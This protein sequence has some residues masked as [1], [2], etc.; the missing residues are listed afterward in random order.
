MYITKLRRNFR[1]H[2][3]ILELPNKMFY[4]GDLLVSILKTSLLCFILQLKCPI[5]FESRTFLFL[6]VI[7]TVCYIHTD[8]LGEL[9]NLPYP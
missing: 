8:V 2:K 4:D 5:N 1:S 7:C 3:L 9:L 6:D